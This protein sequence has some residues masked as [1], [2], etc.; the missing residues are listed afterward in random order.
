MSIIYVFSYSKILLRASHILWCIWRTLTQSAFCSYVFRAK[1]VERRACCAFHVP[2]ARLGLIFIADHCFF[3]H[4]SNEAQRALELETAEAQREQREL[5]CTQM[6]P[7]RWT[8]KY[9]QIQTIF[10]RQ[11]QSISTVRQNLSQQW[12]LPVLLSPEMI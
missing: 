4:R 9:C 7:E 6:E 1:V 3:F 5:S 10:D 2:S 8:L 11:K 12:L